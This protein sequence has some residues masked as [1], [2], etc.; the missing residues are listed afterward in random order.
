MSGATLSAQGRGSWAIEG[1]LNFDTVA[2]IWPEIETLIADSDVLELTLAAVSQTNSAGVALLLEAR[3][4]ARRGRCRLR[5]RDVPSDLLDLA[6]MS[7]CEGLILD[8]R[9]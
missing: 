4:R 3:D 8:P 2:D 9:A 5:I 1:V 6:R 7:R